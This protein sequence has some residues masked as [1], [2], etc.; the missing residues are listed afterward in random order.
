MDYPKTWPKPNPLKPD[1]LQSRITEAQ[2]TD[3]FN[4]R[5][6]TRQLAKDLG[7]HEKYLSYKF[8]FKTEI[9]D[10]KPLI[11]TRKLYKLEIAVQVLQGLH[12]IQQAADIA[13]VS[14]NTMQR[15]VQKAKL[16]KPELVEAYA[17]VVL[18][19]KQQTIQKARSART[20]SAAETLG[21]RL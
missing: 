1:S 3:L 21:D 7:V 4:R 10:K 5:I 2:K 8:A 18:S 20:S 14:Y 13:Y 11:E 16:A 19:Q 17:A 9:I 12:T 6:T 15:C